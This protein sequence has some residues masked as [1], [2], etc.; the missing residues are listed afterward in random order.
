MSEL[1]RILSGFLKSRGGNVGI[2]FGL[3][4]TPLVLAAGAAL[5]Y[6]RASDLHSSLQTGTDATTLL[7]CKASSTLT[8]D[9]LRTMAKDSVQSY[10]GGGTITIKDLQVTNSPRSVVLTTTSSSATAFMKIMNQNT[11]VV[12]A[13]ASCS[14]SEQ[15]FEIALVLDTTG[16]MSSSGGT[17]TKMEAAKTAAKDFVDYMFTTGALPGHVRMSLVPFAAS[18]A[19][20]TASRTAPWLDTTGLSPV[21]WQYVTNPGAAS[22]TSRVSIFDKLK[23][24]RSSWAWEGCVESPPY[25]YNVKDDAVSKG[26]PKSLILPMFAPDEVS[27]R[28]SYRSR[29]DTY[30]YQDVTNSNSYI[31]DGSDFGTG[32]CRSDD[33][34]QSKRFT[35]ACKY[36]ARDNARTSMPG[37]NWGCTSRP[38]SL[39]GTSQSTLKTEITAL[40]PEGSTNVH[41]GFM[42]GW[43]TISPTNVFSS[44]SSPPVAYDTTSYNKVVVLMTDG[45]NQWLANDDVIGK[46]NYSAYGYF[47]NADGTDAATTNSR[48]RTGRT[49]LT[50]NADGRAVID[51]LLLEACT[52]AKAKKVIVYTVGFSTKD[53]PIDAQGL[54]LLSSCATASDYAFVASDSKSLISAFQKIAQGIGQLRLTR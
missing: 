54:N 32:S 42:W 39:L 15:Y 26:T 12:D 16:S 25:P 6:S 31:D 51:E 9:Q 40:Q 29:G 33:S 19:I 43:R 20:P 53:D 1:R 30:Y 34:S 28:A 46:S 35:Q 27:S 45:A 7:L 37:P 50:T 3:A 5:D 13:T 11:V 8:S 21:H 4:I 10:V 24:T 48:F 44:Q 38:L 36:N 17:Q 52:N 23:N 47:R 41:E 49:N 22:F 18:V 14:A 2:I